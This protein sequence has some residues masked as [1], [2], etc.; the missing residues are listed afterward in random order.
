MMAE[1][2]LF[3]KKKLSEKH[4]GN[5]LCRNGHHHWL[6]DKQQVFDV[7]LGRLVTV[8]RCK[9]CRIKKNQLK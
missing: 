3:K 7:K 5:T 1:I 4:K 6:I 8:S 9:R 2:L